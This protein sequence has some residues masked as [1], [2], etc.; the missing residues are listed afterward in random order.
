M[1]QRDVRI[2]RMLALALV[3]VLARPGLAGAQEVEHKI[4]P[5]P[6]KKNASATQRSAAA[7]NLA[8]SW[9]LLTTQPPLLDYFDCGPGSPV[10]LT[11]GT[12][13][14]A[15]NGCQDWWKLTPDQFGSYVNGTWTQL[16][17]LPDDYSRLYHATAVLPDGRVIIEGGEYNVSGGTYHIVWQA[18]GAIYDPVAD[19]WT[20][21]A[22][23]PFFTG[24]GPF[25]QTIGDAQATVL[26][27]GTFMLA[28]CCTRES[29][30]FNADTL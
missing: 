14:L 16:A 6:P 3:A 4:K 9:Q 21:V 8:P 29:A 1:K 23:P 7:A 28:N 15:D 30:L 27:D 24:F 25:A 19:A 20:L 10:L 13:M 12:V 2:L 26:F 22:P 5:L 17:S 18:Q 11:D